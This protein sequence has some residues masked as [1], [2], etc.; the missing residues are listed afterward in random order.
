MADSQKCAEKNLWEKIED[1]CARHPYRALTLL[2]IAML[3]PFLAKPFNFDDPLF[4]W[5]AQQIQVHPANPY[6]FEV[7][8][9]GF[10]QPMWEATQNPPVLSYYLA[11]AAGIFGWSEIGLHFACLLPAVAVVLGTYRLAKNFCRWPLF[12]A[13]ATL[14]APVFLISSTTVMSDVPMLAF[15]IWAVVFWT[16]GLRQNNFLKLSSAGVLVALAILTKYNGVCLIPLLAAY[17]WIEKR[18]V[19]GWAAFLL[20]PVAT[21]CASEL[22][23]LQLYGHAHF[24]TS[25]QFVKNHQAFQG[26][27]KPIKLL[28]TLT[29]TGGCFAAAF[30]CAPFLCRKRALSLFFTSA[31]LLAAFAVIGGMTANY[32]WLAGGNRVGAEIQIVFWTAGGLSVLALALAEL[33]Q[34]RDAHAWLLALWVLGTFVFT[35]FVYWMVNGRALLPM[36]PAVAILIARRL[37]QSRLELPARI[38]FSLAATA[39]L[40]LLAA[41]ADFQLANNAR[42]SAEQ[43]CAKYAAMTGR[44]WFE[45]HWGFQYYMQSFGA[46]PLDVNHAEIQAGDLLV[47]P[48]QNSNALPPDPKIATLLEKFSR[49]EFTGFATMSLEGGAGFY[50]QLWGPLPF[51]FGCIPPEKVS[52]YVLKLPSKNP[53]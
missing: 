23:T 19:G 47:Q 4:V 45:G 52:I 9:Y 24:F 50:S 34:K 14:F 40:S 28:N 10:S 2:T 25:H 17:G 38:K 43:I 3:S 15:W 12:A 37:E 7:N 13:L 26:I 32:P 21:L 39:A 22:L 53:G 42:K 6:G 5:A 49:P 44:L 8:W 30:F 46:R 35:A 16:E 1:G 36:A 20:I 51:A 33:W 29:F 11:V 27:S 18:G 41:Q 48:G 31:I